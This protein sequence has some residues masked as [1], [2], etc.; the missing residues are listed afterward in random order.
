MQEMQVLP[1]SGRTPGGGNGNAFYSCLGSPRDWGAWWATVHGV[2]KESD[3]TEW[4]ST[5]TQRSLKD[6]CMIGLTGSYYPKGRKEYVGQRYKVEW[7]ELKSNGI[8]S[9]KRGKPVLEAAGDVEEVALSEKASHVVSNSQSCGD[10]LF[11]QRACE[12][13]RDGS[14]G[15]TSNENRF[16]SCCL[17]TLCPASLLFALPSRILAQRRKWNHCSP[18]N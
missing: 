5:H 11:I 12:W 10:S 9:F 8:S 16:P 18:P 3:M 7:V 13:G 6:C 4:V 15:S 1:G 2:T 17:L 14:F